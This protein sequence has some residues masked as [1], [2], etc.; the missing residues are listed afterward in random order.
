MER[1]AQTNSEFD[2]SPNQTQHSPSNIEKVRIYTA[3]KLSKTDNMPAEILPGVYIGSVGA[4]MSFGILKS[5]GI[6]H[7][8]CIADRLQPMFTHEFTYKVVEVVDSPDVCII[9]KFSDCFRFIA[10]SIRTGKILVHWYE[11]FSF[12]GKSRSASVCIGF[13]MMVTNCTYDEAYTY[14]KKRRPAIDPN[15]GFVQQLRSLN[16]KSFFQ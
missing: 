7:I 11:L 6:T 5:L 1:E 16:T 14:M 10:A 4:A 12:A 2:K 8:L 15:P 9:E 13:I 3:I